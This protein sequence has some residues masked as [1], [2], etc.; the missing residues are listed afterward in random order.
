MTDVPYEA[1]LR[2]RLEVE[3]EQLKERYEFL[4]ELHDG[5]RCHLCGRYAG[6]RVDYL[7]GGCLRLPEHCNCESRLTGAIQ[8]RRIR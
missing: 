3:L 4:K 7:C 1:L 6:D 2:R 5:T 8:W